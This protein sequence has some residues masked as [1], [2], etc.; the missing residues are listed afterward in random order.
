MR[1]SRSTESVEILS[2]RLD[3]HELSVRIKWRRRNSSVAGYASSMISSE[4][5]TGPENCSVIGPSLRAASVSPVTSITSVTSVASI[6]VGVPGDVEPASNARAI[7]IT[8]SCA[9]LTKC[10]ESGSQGESYTADQEQRDEPRTPVNYQVGEQCDH[11]S[12]EE[13]DCDPVQVPAHAALQWP[14]PRVYELGLA[15]NADEVSVVTVTFRDND[16]G[17]PVG[18][19][20]SDGATVRTGEFS[21][22]I[23]TWCRR[24]LPRERFHCVCTSVRRQPAASADAASFLLTQREAAEHE[25]TCTHE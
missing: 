14:L 12:V 16:L 3:E 24:S 21:Y 23:S 7:R 22:R 8:H 10:Y 4:G 9:Q 2:V 5:V 15:A 1:G 11:A 25:A 18:K 6:P 20:P 17:C 13:R 19:P